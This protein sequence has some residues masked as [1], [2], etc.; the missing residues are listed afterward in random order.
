MKKCLLITVLIILCNKGF[1]QW[2]WAV[3]HN[4]YD[5]ETGICT[6][7]SGNLYVASVDGNGVAGGNNI[8]IAKYDGNGNLMWHYYTF[9][10]SFADVYGICYDGKGHVYISGHYDNLF[11]DITFGAYTLTSDST[12][13]YLVKY[14]T[15]GFVIWAKNV[16][17]GAVETDKSGNIYLG[18]HWGTF[19]KLDTSG[20]IIWTKLY[21]G[22]A[23]IDK[24]DNIYLGDNFI[25]PTLTL[26][27]F[28]LTN[29]LSGTNDFYLAKADT[30]G[31][32]IWAQ[33]F[34]GTGQDYIT[35]VC[36]DS[37]GGAYI[38]GLFNSSTLLIGS[39]TLSNAGGYDNYIAKFDSS[40]AFH[41]AIRNGGAG[42]EDAVSMSYS[43]TGYIYTAGTFHQSFYVGSSAAISTTHTSGSLYCAK[44]DTTGSFVG[45]EIATTNDSSF[46]MSSY[47]SG[48]AIAVDVNNNVCMAGSMVADT[49]F[50]GSITLASPVSTEYYSF[51]AKLGSSFANGINEINSEMSSITLFPNPTSSTFT[52]TSTDKIESVKVY[53]ILGEMVNDKWLMVNGGSASIDIS[54]VSKGIYFAEIKTEK[55]V[56][57]K[58]VVK[59]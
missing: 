54:G 20:N 21:G 43:R 8:Y 58:K 46:S 36:P 7:E 14:D 10:S 9:F 4:L 55:G 32:I 2:Q 12:S 26:G 27:S 57:R 39:T 29:T 34:G 17:D 19:Q 6:D 49:G 23:V 56:V 44:Y 48:P 37:S 16:Y 31:N 45:A 33:S 30:A 53:D 1:G 51:V 15:S 3:H 25:T 40:G 42:D 13:G 50:F 38:A 35:S 5:G 22:W 28:T 18:S 47:F 52:I 11:S 59:E 41:W 24:Y